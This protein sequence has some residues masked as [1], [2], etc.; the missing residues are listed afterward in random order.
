MKIYKGINALSEYKKTKLLNKLQRLDKNITNLEAEY[1]HFVRLS[2]AL[3]EAEDQTLVGLLTYDTKFDSYDSGEKFI[4]LPRPGTI[5]PWSSKATEIAKNAGLDGIERIERGIVYYVT[6]TKKI[7]REQIEPVFYDRMTEAVLAS[8]T[9]AEA[10]FE[11]QKP[12]VTIVIDVLNGGREGLVAANKEFG[13]ALADDEID[14]LVGAYTELGRNP[15]DAE[16][17]MFGA[18]NSEHCRHKVFNA[19]WFIDGQKQPKSLFKMIKNT[20]EK[21][22]EDVLSAYSDNAAVLAG[23]EG[24]RFFVDPDTNEYIVQNEP[25]HTVIKVETHN[26][27]TAIAPWPG[28]ATGSG[29]EIRDEG[30]TGRGA[31]P[32]MGLAGYSVSNLNLPD[33]QQKWEKPYGKPGRISSPLE[34][35]INAPLGAAAFGN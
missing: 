18:V 21:G 10:L 23:E 32:K 26:H 4:V 31:K 30:A 11:E 24:G 8:E 17:M 15:S 5:S 14:Y 3:T 7:N 6:S 19:D 22:G 2:R 13:L 16:L 12:K 34:I 25:I 9:E 33:D 28:A 29:G 1:I 20:Y 35:M 27:P